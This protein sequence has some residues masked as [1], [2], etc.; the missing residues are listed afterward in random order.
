MARYVLR[1]RVM[2][3][4]TVTTSFGNTGILDEPAHE[5][6]R[7]VG[8]RDS[9]E[10]RLQRYVA[11]QPGWTLGK[12]LASAGLLLQTLFTKERTAVDVLMPRPKAPAPLR[13]SCS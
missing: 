7:P 8:G 9:L 11:S 6:P 3:P 2:T 13:R 12:V 4:Y 10:Q 5:T 1:A